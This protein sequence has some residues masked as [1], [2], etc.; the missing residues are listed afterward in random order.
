LKLY[1]QLL[2]IGFLMHFAL[3]FILLSF[4]LFYAAFLSIF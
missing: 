3:S 1:A 2:S 4:I